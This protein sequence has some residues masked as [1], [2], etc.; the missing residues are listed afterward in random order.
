LNK[1]ILNQARQQQMLEDILKQLKPNDESMC[2]DDVI[3]EGFPLDSLHRFNEVNMTLKTDK[4]FFR[5]L[6]NIL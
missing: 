5:K 3:L 2:D 1:V 4:L 6:V